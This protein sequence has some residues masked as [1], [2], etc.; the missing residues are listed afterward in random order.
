MVDLVCCRGGV[1]QYLV[2]A[3]EIVGGCCG[4]CVS[5][6]VLQYL[7]VVFIDLMQVIGWDL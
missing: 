5:G 2:I 7:L 1:L 3:C 6:V 4:Y